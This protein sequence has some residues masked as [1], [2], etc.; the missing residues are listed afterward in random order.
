MRKGQC[1]TVTRREDLTPH[2]RA[3]MAKFEQ[4]LH[5]HKARKEGADPAACDL[6][7]QAIYPEGI[8]RPRE[9]IGDA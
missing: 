5:V 3:A 7:E 8:G 9:P 1:G 2:D 4:F 6:L